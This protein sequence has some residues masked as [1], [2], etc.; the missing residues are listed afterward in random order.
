MT[1]PNYVNPSMQEGN[2]SMETNP[3]QPS[4]VHIE[5]KHPFTSAL[6]DVLEFLARKRAERLAKSQQEDS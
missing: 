5:P 3:A 4:N 1:T 2:V 6:A